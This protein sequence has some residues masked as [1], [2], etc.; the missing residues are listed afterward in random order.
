MTDTLRFGA[1]GAARITPPALCDA[2]RKTPGVVVRAVAARDRARAEEFAAKHG[3]P[4]VLGSYEDLVA[5][6][7]VDCVYNALPN[8]LHC[9]WTIRALRAGKHVLCEKPFASNA[10]EAERMRAAARETGRR[11]VEAFHWRYHPLAARV[12]E[13]LDGGAIGRIQRVEAVFTV[14]LPPTDIRFDY[15]L[16][17]GALM[18]LGCYTV[19]F[20]RFVAGE[21]EVISAEIEQGPPNVD[22]DTRAELRVPGGVTGSVYCS[23]KADKRFRAAVDVTGERGALQV[24]N[25]LAPHF[26]H[27]IKLTVGDAVQT[28]KVEGEATYVHQLRAFADHVRK[29]VPVPTDPDD[30]VAN[31]RVID[32]IY[33]AA[34]LPV[35]GT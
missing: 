28:E 7:E 17:G 22:V 20:A 1:L 13:L 8:S 12:R 18:D 33:R 11:L 27:E 5:S 24:T 23:M 19:S 29:G 3:I 9:E 6:P 4:V 15:A 26:G 32:A 30:A 2:A 10:A 31:M 34:G 35:R 21:P 25:P 14:R 16:A